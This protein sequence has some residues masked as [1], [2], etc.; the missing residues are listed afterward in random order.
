M[1]ILSL[2]IDTLSVEIV[3]LNLITSN[4]DWNAVQNTR[5]MIE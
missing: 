4:N 2:N 5:Y 1:G 3:A